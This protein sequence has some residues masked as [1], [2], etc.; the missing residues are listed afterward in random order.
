MNNKMRLAKFCL[1]NEHFR[2]CCELASV[3][4]TM[5]QASKFR[6]KQGVAF[7]KND[8]AIQDLLKKKAIIN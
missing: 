4:P 1:E 7:A 6:N 5:R 2:R 8:E 3:E